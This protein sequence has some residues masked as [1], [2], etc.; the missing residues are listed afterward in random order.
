MVTI[1]SRYMKPSSMPNTEANS[2][3]TTAEMNHESSPSIE[4]RSR[5]RKGRPRKY[6]STHT[7]KTFVEGISEERDHSNENYGYCKGSM[8]KRKSILR[9]SGTTS[10]KKMS[11]PT[12]RTQVSLAAKQGST[13]DDETS[14]AIS[15]AGSPWLITVQDGAHLDAISNSL[16]DP[17]QGNPLPSSKYLPRR[18]LKLSM[19]EY[20]IPSLESHDVGRPWECNFDG[21]EARVH[22]ASRVSGLDKVR[23][24]LRTHISDS[25]DKI[26]LALSE[27]RPYL[28]VQ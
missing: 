3:G 19:T 18:Y 24:H 20:N 8:R 6:A 1:R 25:Q 7:S 2:M 11:Q 10:A 28:P 15:C 16:L 12:K 27:S 21:C 13:C 26:D 5:R 9:P 22:Q 17:F 4:P 23:D 14:M